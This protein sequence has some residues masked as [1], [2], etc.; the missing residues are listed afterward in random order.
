MWMGMVCGV[1][2]EAGTTR[3]TKV[4]P[5]LLDEKGRHTL[6]PSLYERDAYQA[7]LRKNPGQVSA[8]RFDVRWKV[9]RGEA[10]DL[11]LR[12][13]VRGS[14]EPSVYTIEEGVERR[15]W[16]DRWSS[17]TLDGETLGE[18]GEVVAWRVTLWS[19]TRLLAEERSFL[20]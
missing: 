3:I 5:H 1:G 7:F 9:R 8:L 20:W 10:V 6:S 12:V 4:L 16:Y 2:V 14:K 13:E 15:P 19:G 18:V 11:R 17:V